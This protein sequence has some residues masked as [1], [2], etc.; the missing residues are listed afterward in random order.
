LLTGLYL[1]RSEALLASVLSMLAFDFFFVPPHLT[2]AV[3][4][5]QYLLTFAGL[6]VV[7][8]VISSLAARVR[9]Q[10]DVAQRKEGQALSLYELARSLAASG[11][12]PA[13]L[14]TVVTHVGRTF[15]AAAAVLMPD[16]AAL[17]V[18]AATPGLELGEHELAVATWVWQKG[19]E[20]GPGTGTLEAAAMRYIPLRAGT[21]V[22]GALGVR[23]EL[24]GGYLPPE[25][26]QLLEAFAG[27]AALAIARVHLAEQA[28]QLQLLKATESLQSS[29]LNSISHD[30]RTPLATITGVLSSLQQVS[31]HN[32]G[33]SLDE[34]TFS[35]LVETALAEAERL[36]HLV[37]NLLDMT[38]LEAGA[39]RL[40]AEPCDVQDLL[41][42]VLAQIGDRARDHRVEVRVPADLP[43]VPLDFVLIAQVL[44][45]L[46]DN[47]IK[48]SPPG[49]PIM[50]AAT[51]TD[52]RIKMSVADR[53][54]GI[55]EEDLER[56]FD[57]FYRVG[58]PEGVTGTG[59]GLAISR[60]IIEAHGGRITASNRP[61]GGTLI[62][63]S[64]PLAAVVPPG[65]AES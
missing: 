46:L 21:T 25:E 5:T 53:G 38:R 32:G 65:R 14:Q 22:V 19:H 6:L 37:G 9:G 62:A 3:S 41:G 57:K 42:A 29:L 59:L 8:L 51:Q 7:G 60:G 27:L 50:L 40:H 2:L 63:F 26:R 52:D 23:L 16:G 48:Y 20:A 11:E 15:D 56:V 35:E 58:R 13:L 55:P 33:F 12:L 24:T 34:P 47:A 43:L 17:G 1:G 39:L 44:T 36:N 28:G 18:A 31:Q 4:D 49:E 61:E 54:P 10:A 45:N 30:L 64:L